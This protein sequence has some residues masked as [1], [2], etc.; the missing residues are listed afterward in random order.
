MRWLITEL[1]RRDKVLASTGF[2]IAAQGFVLLELMSFDDQVIL[3]VDRWLKPFK[4]CVSV[5]IFLWTVAWLMPHL[6][7]GRS[8]RATLR[9]N[10]AP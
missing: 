3:G 10:E 7:A 2:L 4:F 9:W 1:S 5:P 8:L 6:P